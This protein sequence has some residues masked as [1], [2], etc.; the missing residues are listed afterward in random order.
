MA[1][2]KVNVQLNLRTWSQVDRALRDIARIDLKVRDVENRFNAKIAELKEQMAARV[3]PLAQQKARLE[4]DIK[5]FC[6]FHRDEFEKE[7]TKVFNFGKLGFRKTPA[8]LKTLAR[9][10]WAKVLMKLEEIGRS[11]FIR[12]KKSVDKDA[13]RT[14]GLNEDE[15]RMLGLVLESKEEFWYECDHHKLDNFQPE[16]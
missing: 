13:I 15:L 10:T 16:R 5:D 11:D 4:R 6:E 7:K 3:E 1:R 14:A 12:V 2:Q 9:W 8:A